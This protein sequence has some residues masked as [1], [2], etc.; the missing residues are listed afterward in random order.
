MSTSENTS[1]LQVSNLTKVYGREFQLGSRKIGRR[2]EAVTDVSFSVKKGEIFGFLGPNGAGKTTTIRSILGYL[3]IKSGTIKING[4]DYLSDALEIREGL[5]FIRSEIDLYGNFTGEEIISYFGKFRPID[6]KFLKKLRSIFKV[7]LTLDFKN[8]STGNRQQVII[9]TALASNPEFVILDEPSS[10][11]DPLMATRFHR[12]LLQMRDEGKTIFLSSHNLTEVQTI[13]DRVGIIRKG[14]IIVIETVKELRRKSMQLLSV[15][16]VDGETPDLDEFQA[17]PNI[18]SVEKKANT[19]LVKVKE[20]VNDLLKFVTSR[21]VKRMTLE[22]S[23][24]EDIFL[25]YYKDELDLLE[26]E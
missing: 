23:S 3:S 2:V 4:L 21:R 22:D 18:F 10:G 25:T 14:K 7:D 20:D 15:E 24:L 11:L 19:F 1:V 6:Q 26:E 5:G 9:I 12:L 13:C 16:F 17:I 8:L